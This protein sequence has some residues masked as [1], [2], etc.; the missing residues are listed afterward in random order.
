[1]AKIPWASETPATTF[2]RRHEVDFSLHP[3][4]YVERGGAQ[5]GA[6]ALGLPLHAVVK[7][8][9]MQDE[10]A[11]PLL[12]L[13]HGDRN[14]S[15]RALARQAGARQIEPCRPEVAQRMSGYLVGGTSPFATRRTM[16]VYLERSILGLSRI[17][18]NGGRRGLLV[19]IEPEVCVR[20]LGAVAVDCALEP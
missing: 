4:V 2:L 10:R 14:V 19:G 18:V 5:A 12:V 3:Y 20:L 13:M 17:Y 11:A 9:V 1:M 6:E 8:L 15:T 16:P 7:T